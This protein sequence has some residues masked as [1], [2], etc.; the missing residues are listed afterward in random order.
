MDRFLSVTRYEIT[1]GNRR[2]KEKNGREK[3]RVKE[4][5]QPLRSVRSFCPSFGFTLTLRTN[6]G[7]SESS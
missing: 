7:G 6:M 4:T 5:P 2:K 1:P 3:E